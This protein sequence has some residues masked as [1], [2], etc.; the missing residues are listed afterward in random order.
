LSAGDLQLRLSPAGRWY[1]FE[2]VAGHWEPDGP[3][4]PEP[5]DLVAD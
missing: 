3:A 4:S 5:T 2:K 1:R